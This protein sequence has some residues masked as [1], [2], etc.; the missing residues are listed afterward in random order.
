MSVYPFNFFVRYWPVDFKS[1]VTVFPL[2][3]R[4]DLQAVFLRQSRDRAEE[5]ADPSAETDIVGVRPYTEGDSMKRIHWKSSARTG[6]LKTRL[7]DG[8]SSR[9]GRVIDLDRLVAGSAERGLSMAAFA[10]T[11]SMKVRLPVGLRS[12]REAVSPAASRGHMLDLLTRL[13]LYE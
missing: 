6:K 13:A 12:R 11:E 7:Y 9:S 4:C 8:A 3:L 5:G 2:P 1:V 10:I